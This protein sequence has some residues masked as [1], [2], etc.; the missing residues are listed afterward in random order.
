MCCGR[1]R[2]KSA[3]GCL[4]SRYAR[5]CRDRRDC[6]P[7]DH[8]AIWHRDLQLRV[9][10]LLRHDYAYPKHH[11]R[12]PIESPQCRGLRTSLGLQLPWPFPRKVWSNATGTP[13]SK[14]GLLIQRQPHGVCR[15]C[16]RSQQ[17]V[18]QVAFLLIPVYGINGAAIATAIV[19]SFSVIIFNFFVIFV[20]DL[21]RGTYIKAKQE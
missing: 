7:N 11:G 16:P 5:C 4:F 17:C 18:R 6:G 13:Y 21:N 2:R 14:K 9:V 8:H 15:D 10:V 1:A 19:Y 20:T 3:A 12:E